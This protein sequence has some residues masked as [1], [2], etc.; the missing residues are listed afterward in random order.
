MG[1]TFLQEYTSGILKMDPIKHLN[2]AEYLQEASLKVSADKLKKLQLFHEMLRKENARI[3]V[4][5]L[6]AA[7]AMGR[8][9]YV[10]SLLPEKL[11]R[12]AGLDLVGPC[13]DLGSGGGFPGIPL[14]ILRPDIHFRLVEGRKKRTE[15][16]ASVA[17]KLGLENVEVIS[18]KLNPADRIECNTAI[19]RA[20][21]SIPDTLNLCNLSLN[22]GGHFIFWKGPDCDHEIEAAATDCPQWSFFRT[23]D[24]R[25]PGTSDKRRLV[26]FTRLDLESR[27][28]SPH[29]QQPV[30][31]ERNDSSLEEAQRAPVKTPEKADD[32]FNAN[33]DSPAT[34]EIALSDRHGVPSWL[35]DRIRTIESDA[36]PRFKDWARLDQSKWIKKTGFTLVSGRKIVPEILNEWLQDSEVGRSASRVPEKSGET[37]GGGFSRMGDPRG[38]KWNGK[39]EALLIF[40][41]IPEELYSMLSEGSGLPIFR[42][43]GELFR[44]LDHSGTK[45][46]ILLWNLDGSERIPELAEKKIGPAHSILVL[47]LSLPDNLGAAIRTARGFGVDSILLTTETVFP[48]HPAVIRSSSGSCLRANFFQG[49]ELKHVGDPLGR[50]GI[51]PEARFLLDHRSQRPLKQLSSL[52]NHQNRYA[53]IVGEEGKG[54][55]SDL[56]GERFRIP[57]SGLESLNAAASLTALLYEWRRER[58]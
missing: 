32:G 39:P 53:F 10:D 6:Y 40:D 14:A 43:K 21:M 27:E 18:R 41:S 2:I 9:H 51:P 35:Q 4:T 16:L 24:Y 3:N 38:P 54:L 5:R 58:D 29:D 36:N 52:L 13:M 49:P 34:H 47:P 42:L 1:G 26:V 15:F 46:P 30:T 55:P 56:K 23:I 12:E 11:L 19:S 20:F 7:E 45:Y 57:I 48:F 17:S 33:P 28:L 44:K 31:V 22:P 37:D 50:S 25:L 8:K